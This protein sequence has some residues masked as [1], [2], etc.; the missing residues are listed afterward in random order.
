MARDSWEDGNLEE[1]ARKVVQGVVRLAGSDEAARILGVDGT[2]EDEVD[3]P[4]VIAPLEWIASE[5]ANA[6]RQA[7]DEAEG[8]DDDNET[9]ASAVSL[10]TIVALVRLYK[11]LTGQTVSEPELTAAVLEF[12]N[13]E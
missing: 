6:L 11:V 5:I 10:S 3:L 13:E 1:Q 4:F 12:L 8:D 7:E 2:L 9:P